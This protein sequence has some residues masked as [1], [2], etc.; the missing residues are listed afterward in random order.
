M[1]QPQHSLKIAII[2]AG[3]A[4]TLTARILRPAHSVTIYE[5]A[6]DA[7]ELGAAVSIGPNG[8]QIL[9]ELGFDRANAGSIPQKRLRVYDQFGKLVSEREMDYRGLY[10]ADFLVHH[11]V[12]IRNEF[13]RLATA[14]SAEVGVE[15]VP[16]RVCWGCEVVS[17]DAEGGRIG[18]ADGEVVE[19]DLVIGLFSFV[20]EF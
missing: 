16:A 10:G 9:D 13:L 8:V 18:F 20:Y 2:G 14:E 11:R 12:D 19:A 15:G 7:T 1:N 6:P 5:R 17:V 3:L 4:G